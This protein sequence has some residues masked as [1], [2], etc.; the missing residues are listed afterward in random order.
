MKR[1]TF[2]KRP[3]YGDTHIQMGFQYHN[4]LS[5]DG[6]PYWNE[7][8]AYEFTLEEVERIE[9]ATEELHTMCLDAVG[10]IV[11]SGDYPAE[12]GLNNTAK[13]LIE[14]SW[15]NKEP[16][17][18]GRFDLCVNPYDKSIKMFEYNA[19]TPTSLLEAGVAQWQWLEETEGVNDQFNSIHDKLIAKWSELKPDLA[20]TLHLFASRD[21]HYEDWGNVEYM[22]DVASQAGW[23]IHID[24]IENVGY[25]SDKKE[26]VN[27]NDQIILDAFK[28]YAWEWMVNDEFG[29][30]ILMSNARWY[31][32]AWKMLLSN[33]AI[34]PVLWE[35]NKNH[36]NLLPAYY[37]QR[38]GFIRKPILGRE[39][40]NI[41]IQD[42]LAEGSHVVPEY[43]KGYIYQE[44][45]ELPKFD[46]YH[47][48][49]GSWVIGDESAGIG[50]REDRTVI[51]GNGSH[52]VPH[53]FND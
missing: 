52:F 27:Q 20:P 48:V 9:T 18:Y 41:Y 37:N 46:G 35:N 17:I 38:S 43:D 32:P 19:D 3:N 25:D 8:V 28:L 2:P 26:F 14:Y 34:L 1:K 40:A 22:A 5:D 4:T 36:K 16:H 15:Y 44:Y 11:E 53:Y 24:D 51:S 30:H 21:G 49:V 47:P 12:F 13:S 42:K 31:E 45:C 10:K 29:E 50:I 33:K 39:G 6:Q 7:G 23:N